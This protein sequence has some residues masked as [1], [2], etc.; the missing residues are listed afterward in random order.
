[1]RSLP[2]LIA[3]MMIAATT[4]AGCLELPEEEDETPEPG[5][6]LGPNETDD[7]T[8]PASNNNRLY[9]HGTGPDDVWMSTDANESSTT[10]TT[11]LTATSDDY[12]V[13]FGLTPAPERTVNMT[14]GDAT[15]CLQLTMS[16]VGMGPTHTVALLVDGDQV[17]SATAP[18]QT[19]NGQLCLALEGLDGIPT[20]ADVVL[21]L[22]VSPEPT[23]LSATWEMDLDG[24]SHLT[25]PIETPVYVDLNAT[26]EG[27]DSSS[28]RA[29]GTVQT[30]QQGGTW[31]AEKTITLTGGVGSA[32]TLDVEFATGNGHLD[33]T[34]RADSTYRV[35]VELAGHGETED[36][37]RQKLDEIRV[38]H[39]DDV[40]GGTMTLR[41]RATTPDNNWN[42]QT[43]HIE[44]EI[45][46]QL[47]L[48]SLSMDTGNG[49]IDAT[50]LSGGTASLDTGNGGVDLNGLTFDDAEASSG[51]GQIRVDG[52][53]FGALGI[54]TGNGQVDV[55]GA[56]AGDLSA[57]TGNGQ[58]DIS[59]TPTGGS[60]S[61]DTG[62][63]AIDITVPDT[64]RYGYDA[65][66]DTSAYTGTVTIDLADTEPV[67]EQEA[68]S[69]HERTTDYDSRDV[70]TQI[71]ASTG[72]GDVDIVGS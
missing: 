42:N 34:P 5:P 7:L 37:A 62:N 9:F 33:A 47:A 63:G 71:G 38:N 40:A 69:K 25:L 10:L 21:R 36:E 22:T 54:D 67:G 16:N 45:P 13:E 60:W 14:D 56:Q 12:V 35:V 26:G 20:D 2:I 70:T 19:I 30:Y 29:D 43:A 4:V 39:S 41:T 59:A 28:R 66:G 23:T 55:E 48:G 49:A 32:S 24:R 6:T 8:Q 65:Q 51:N 44:G 53:A 68:H 15:A 17:A 64:A 52:G 61:A 50:D 27:G 3:L 11:T 72:N 58:I 57:S 1:M 46:T 18:S 31:Y